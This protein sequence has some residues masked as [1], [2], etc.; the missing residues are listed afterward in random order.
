M[1]QSQSR[2]ES[3][4]AKFVLFVERGFDMDYQVTDRPRATLEGQQIYLDPA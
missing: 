1:I 4:E 2:Q 3:G